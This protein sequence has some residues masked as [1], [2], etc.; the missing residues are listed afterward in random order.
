MELG[1]NFAAAAAAVGFGI[2]AGFDS[3]SGAAAG[4][5]TDAVEVVLVFGLFGNY[6]DLFDC[7]CRWQ[8]YWLW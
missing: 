1:M 5:A 4:A 8:R 2:D 6:S 3:G 7:R